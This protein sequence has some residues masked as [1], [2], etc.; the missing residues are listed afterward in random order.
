MKAVT[1]FLLSLVFTAQASAVVLPYTFTTTLPPSQINAN[2]SALRDATNAHEALRNGHNTRL[3]DVTTVNSSVGTHPINFN[4][5]ELFSARVENLSSDPSCA[6]GVLG[7]VI[8]N[9]TDHLMK[10]CDGSSFVSIA[11]SGVNTLASVLGAGN[12]AGAYNI[13]LNHNQLLNAKVENVVTAPSPGHTGR[14]VFD[15]SDSTLKV[16]TG[17]VIQA[18]GGAQGLS[19]TLGVSNSAGATNIDFNGNQAVKLRGEQLASSPGT[20]YAGRLYYNTVSNIF[21]FYNGASWLE[22]GNTNGI[23]QVL[24]LGNATG[25]L[26]IDLGGGQLLNSVIHNNSGAPSSGVPGQIWFDTA[27][28]FLSYGTSGANQAVASIAGTQTLTNKSISGSA[29]TITN[30]QDSSLSSNIP[31]KDTA[32]SISGAWTF[33]AGPTVSSLKTPSGSTHILTDGLT[34]DTITLNNAA[35]VLKGKTLEA[36]TLSGNQDFAGFKAVNMALESL[37]SNPSNAAGRVYY[38]SNTGEMRYSTGSNWRVL[39]SNL[40]GASIAL[41]DLSA[42]APLAYNNTTG[43]FSIPLGTSS[44]DGYLSAPDRAAFLAKVSS[45]RAINTTAPLTGGGD[46]SADR[47]IA[48]PAATDAVAGYLTSAD[49]TTYSGYAATIAGKQ[50]AGNYITSLTTDVVASGAGA[51]AATIQ[52]NVVTNAKTAQMAAHTFKGNN[53]GST[54]NSVD[55]TAAQAAAELDGFFV[56]SVGTINSQ[57]KSA[58]GAVMTAGGQLDFQTADVSFPGMVST[59]PQKIAGV[60][61]LAASPIMETGI[62]LQD[63]GVGTNAISLAAPTLASSY[64]VVLP[65]NKCNPNEVWKKSASGDGYECAAMSG[66]GASI[67]T[68]EIAYT[69]GVLGPGSTNTAN[70]KW[71]TQRKLAGT[72]V[73]FNS[74]ATSTLGNWVDVV[75]AGMCTVTYVYG[76]GQSTTTFGIAVDE[77]GSQL[78]AGGTTLAG[79]PRLLAYTDG[80]RAIGIGLTS[81]SWTTIT[82]TG[83]LAAGAKIY[84]LINSGAAPNSN[85]F[86]HV[87][88][89]H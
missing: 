38:N 40:S 39:T 60:K 69:N 64:S 19:S 42:T 8:W 41:T 32:A 3:E 7:K 26:G 37:T 20:T 84:F 53:T 78:S 17:S 9:T 27:T 10:V 61:T 85:T 57:I 49:H 86:F 56:D 79:N 66:G 52:P 21:K 13:D 63:P 18:I 2:F 70:L 43:V 23:A 6:A 34:D 76:D 50:A 80:M 59:G 87:S 89:I 68:S 77:T 5:K 11:G 1:W 25:G 88:C 15:T 24:A 44:V 65:V 28:G 51:A 12:S 72:G 73:A 75:T 83:Y 22:I 30:I 33:S 54:A 4:N 55:M 71:N 35:Q 82:W 36:P 62:D 81:S 45:T 46:L 48:I 47:T 67:T 14:L 31:K 74:S 16:D 58:N 29:N